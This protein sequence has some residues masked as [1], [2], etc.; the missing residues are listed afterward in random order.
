[1]F[2]AANDGAVSFGQYSLDD[3]EKLLASYPL[4]G[5][6]ASCELDFNWELNRCDVKRSIRRVADQAKWHFEQCQQSIDAGYGSPEDREFFEADVTPRY[7][8]LYSVLQQVTINRSTI[9]VPFPEWLDT[10]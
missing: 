2:W 3:M 1:L 6:Y 7:E 4:Y 5:G 8:T 9:T 10:R